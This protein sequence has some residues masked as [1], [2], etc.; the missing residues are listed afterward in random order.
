MEEKYIKYKK[1]YLKLK[2][3][4]GGNHC[5][6]QPEYISTDDYDKYSN[7]DYLCYNKNKIYY[8][9]STE[10]EYIENKAMEEKK[11][12]PERKVILEKNA[13]TSNEFF[14]LTSE[15]KE[16][17]TRPANTTTG[18]YVKKSHYYSKPKPIDLIKKK[19]L[20][21]EEWNKLTEEDQEKFEPV[22]EQVQTGLQEFVEMTVY[23]K[24]NDSI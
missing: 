12:E 18:N 10:N 9:R 4:I 8:K 7:F 3:Q 5:L 15:Q 20:S 21:K 6:I 24:K 11:L 22:K 17:Y 16:L 13:I 14:K 2:Y 1:K 23:K 19:K